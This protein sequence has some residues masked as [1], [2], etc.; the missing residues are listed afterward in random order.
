MNDSDRVFVHQFA[1]LIGGLSVLTVVL[2]LVALAIYRHEP[3]ETNPNAQ[4]QVDARIAPVGAV[5]AGNTG[6][7]AMQAAAEAA[8][9]AAASQVAYGGST[10]GKTIYDNLCH[11]CHTAGIAGAPKLGDKAMWA[12]RVA[13]GIDTLVKHAI[14]GYH[15]PDGNFMPP[16][17]GNP[18]LT[19]EQVKAAVTWIVG[20]AK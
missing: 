13:Q 15:G 5:Y 2:I 14:D 6:R 10:D 7:A 16:K 3:K 18:A 17:G 12:P 9:K 20:Q 11:S 4:P 1:K 19:D 8:S